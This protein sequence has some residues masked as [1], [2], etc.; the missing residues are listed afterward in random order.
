VRVR[1]LQ[2]RG[3]AL[4]RGE[5]R[6]D[7]PGAFCCIEL[8][9]PADARGLVWLLRAL[10]QPDRELASLA[11]WSPGRD[12]RAALWLV[13]GGEA[14]VLAAD[15][16]QRRMQLGRWHGAANA[17]RPQSSEA[18]EIAAFFAE[19]CWPDRLDFELLRTW[20]VTPAEAWPVPEEE[21]LPTAPSLALATSDS[22]TDLVRLQVELERARAAQ[23]RREQQRARAEE[24]RV[25]RGRLAELEAELASLQAEL[26]E[27]AP[28]AKLASDGIEGRSA[29]YRAA[30]QD[31]DA[32]RQEIQDQRR[33]LLAER[34]SLR[35]GRDRHA[36]PLWLGIASIALGGTLSGLGEWLGAAVAALGLWL[37]GISLF[38]RRGSQRRLGRIE[39]VLAAQRVRERTAE[40]R[41]DSETEP[42]RAA[43]AALDLDGLDQLHGAL[44]AHLVLAKRAAELKQALAA[45]QASG[46]EA[47]RELAAIE[48]SL[49]EPDPGERAR[50]LEQRAIEL[51]RARAE[52]A[53]ALPPASA[54]DPEQLI[55]A[56]ARGTGLAVDELRGR[57]AA[58]LPLYLSALC[59]RD[60][61]HA[62]HRAPEGWILRGPERKGVRFAELPGGL[63]A[64]VSLAFQLA[65]VERTALERNAPFL[66]GPDCP[67]L[68]PEET[69]ALGR[70]LR[71]L[72][73]FVQVIRVGAPDPAWAAHADLVSRVS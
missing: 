73:G 12:A 59:A 40:Q 32:V 28:L 27:Q 56:A 26:E 33:M 55:A 41:F 10:L 69:R 48:A 24:L 57:L 11:A 23:A 14:F 38:K 36:L 62:R 42:F 54:P 68:E 60:L 8:P 20:G 39:A 19:R 4:P 63:S 21:T 47:A 71:R 30:L 29:A 17:Y 50:A 67:P 49:A 65:L 2:F 22:G 61:T 9:G 18:G 51:T 34:S 43:L 53:P 7:L 58:A 3:L 15:A 13:S 46:S 25:R 72:S 52:R 44:E 45:E 37:A 1:G 16:G 35:A 5:Q 31:R 70:A 66:I 6:L 64:R